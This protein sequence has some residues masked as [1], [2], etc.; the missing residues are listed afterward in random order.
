MNPFMIAVEKGHLE[1]VKAM[2]KKNPDLVSSSTGFKSTV[3]HWALEKD[4][5]RSAFFQVNY[6]HFILLF[7]L[8]CVR[9]HNYPM[10]A[11]ANS[12]KQLISLFICHFF[13]H[14]VA[15]IGTWSGSPPVLQTT[16]GQLMV[17]C[18]YPL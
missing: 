10:G 11:Y 16:L 6:K 17:V 7:K 15:N 12:V 4:T 1:V 8:H 3:I 9:H 18:Y 2:M 14:A 5:N 13:G